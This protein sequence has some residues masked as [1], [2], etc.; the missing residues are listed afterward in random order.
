MRVRK[1]EIFGPILP[2]IAVPDNAAAIRHVNS[3]DR[4]LALYWFGADRVAR[5]LVLEKTLSGGVTINDC[6]LHLAQENQPFGGV[7]AS[8]TGAYHG[9]W[10][11]RNFSK[12]KPV[13]FR[14]KLSALG[15]SR[16]PYGPG[17]DTLL[18]TLRRFT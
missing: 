7:G 13:Y 16:P 3:H 2:I 10:G 15:L 18:K 8:G 14:S 5:D 11:F 4:P 12:E 17:F 9:E 6:L 1:E